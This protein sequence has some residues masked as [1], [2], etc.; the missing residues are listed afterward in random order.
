MSQE[1]EK[2]IPPFPGV[3]ENGHI[4]NINLR[5]WFAGQAL[6]GILSTN[7]GIKAWNKSDLELAELSYKIAF[8]MLTARK[9]EWKK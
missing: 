8:A 3:D 5:D 6:V 7:A 4:P 9:G 1:N 2:R